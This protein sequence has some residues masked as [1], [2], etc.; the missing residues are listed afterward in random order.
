MGGLYTTVEGLLCAVR[1]NLRASDPYA[2]GAVDSGGAEVEARRERMA[3]FLA[4]LG[5]C[6]DGEDA[7]TLILR[8]PMANSW[9]YSPAAD[10]H[11]A[12]A[13]LDVVEYA[14]TEAEDRDLGLL[15]MRTED[16]AEEHEAA[17]RAKELAEE[18]AAAAAREQPPHG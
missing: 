12:D 17:A 16:Y 15:D 4:R 7:F 11:A 9:V 6:I 18:A 8:D 14:R 2:S 13:A 3:D 1:D 5:R 10:A